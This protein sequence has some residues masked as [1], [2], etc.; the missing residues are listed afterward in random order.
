MPKLILNDKRIGINETNLQLKIDKQKKRILKKRGEFEIEY[1][2]HILEIYENFLIKSKKI[3]IDVRNEETE[4]NINFNYKLLIIVTIL[5]LLLVLFI[6]LSQFLKEYLFF[7]II[8]VI[9]IDILML[10]CMGIY[11]M[12]INN[13]NLYKAI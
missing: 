12:E 10:V 5:H 2:E 7:S 9:I 4:I 3:K 1:G 6:V 13:K 11:N 8:F